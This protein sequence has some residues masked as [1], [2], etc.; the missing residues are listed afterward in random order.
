L[1]YAHEWPL[2][3]YKEDEDTPVYDEPEGGVP[4]YNE[5]YVTEDW[6]NTPVE[7]EEAPQ[8]ENEELDMGEDGDAEAAREQN[9]EVMGGRMHE[10]EEEDIAGFLGE[11]E[12]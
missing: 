8:E 7:E 5:T 1:S 3:N 12:D 11:D 4:D 10:G 6:R 2:P 9:A